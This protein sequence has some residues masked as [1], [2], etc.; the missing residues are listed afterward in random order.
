MD[1]HSG[2]QKFSESFQQV[3]I[4][5]FKRKYIYSFLF[6]CFVLNVRKIHILYAD[7]CS[8]KIWGLIKSGDQWQNQLLFET[9]LQITAFGQDTKGEI[10][11]LS[12]DGDVYQLIRK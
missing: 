2:R 4:C 9:H 3:I 6:S 11:L 1:D 7:Y 8:G 5:A 12:D 10:Y